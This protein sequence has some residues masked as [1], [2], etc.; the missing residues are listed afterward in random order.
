MG[1]GFTLALFII[2]AIREF[3]GAGELFGLTVTKAYEPAMLFILAPGALLT[4]G[5][6]IGFTNYKFKR[7]H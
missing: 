5:L 2:A 4:I 6:I 3:F 7:K 1:A